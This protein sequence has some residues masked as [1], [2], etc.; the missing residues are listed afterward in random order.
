MVVEIQPF[1]MPKYNQIHYVYITTHNITGEYYIGKRTTKKD[2]KQSPETD[3]Y[4]GSGTWVKSILDK[5]LLTKTVVGVYDSFD[6]SSDA[7]YNLIKEHI[8]NPLCTNIRVCS[9]SGHFGKIP[10][11]ETKLKISVSLSGENNHNFGKTPSDETKLK[12]SVRNSGKIPSEETRQKLSIA[13]MG[14][15]QKASTKKKIASAQYGEKNHAAKLTQL[16]VEQIRIMLSDGLK[17]KDIASR[18]GVA[19]G[20]IS[21]IHTGVRW[22]AV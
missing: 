3:N 15:T 19:E 11:E 8:E 22:S 14:R 16:Q 4:Y 10:S 5:T 7:E 21:K 2:I 12:I 9:S 20:T 1:F 13:G 18:F 17:Q 6:E